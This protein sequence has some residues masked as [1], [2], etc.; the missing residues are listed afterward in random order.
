MFMN[1]DVM[2]EYRF[3]PMDDEFITDKN[4]NANLYALLQDYASYGST[5]FYCTDGKY[6]LTANLYHTPGC[7]ELARLLAYG[8]ID[9]KMMGPTKTEIEKD[10]KTLLKTSKTNPN[11]P[12]IIQRMDDFNICEIYQFNLTFN[13][14]RT[15]TIKKDIVNIIR[16]L[17]KLCGDDLLK[18]YIVLLKQFNKE[19]SSFIFTY[20]KLIELLGGYRPKIR[21]FNMPNYLKDLKKSHLIDFIALTDGTKNDV[22][23]QLLEVA[24]DL[25]KQDPAP[26]KLKM[27]IEL[28]ADG[29]IGGYWTPD[30]EPEETIKEIN[31]Y[32]IPE[33]GLLELLGIKIDS[34]CKILKYPFYK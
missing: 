16:S 9:D 14:T 30:K 23:Y 28:N 10:L 25:P 6:Q 20:D 27:E 24:R 13:N 19:G 15:L 1:D 22:S 18:L 21:K 32:E 8:F 2:R 3:F 31:D 29:T 12:Y 7:E 5:A 33:P 17:D 26:M 11:R 4:I 34:N